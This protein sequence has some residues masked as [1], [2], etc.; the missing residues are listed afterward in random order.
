[1]CRDKPIDAPARVLSLSLPETQ[2]RA[3]MDMEPEPI[4]WLREQ[5]RERLQ[6]AVADGDS[7]RADGRRTDVCPTL[8]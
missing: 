4:T 3:L 2:W 1:M 6:D 7:D 5:I 8:S